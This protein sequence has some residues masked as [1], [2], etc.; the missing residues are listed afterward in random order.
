LG[1]FKI[2]VK[3]RNLKIRNKEIAIEILMAFAT[4]RIDELKCDDCCFFYKNS[5]CDIEA[6]GFLKEEVRRE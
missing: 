4:C 3:M 5:I 6:I 2:K 1:R